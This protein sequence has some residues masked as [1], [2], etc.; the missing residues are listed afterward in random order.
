MYTCEN[1]WAFKKTVYGAQLIYARKELKW[2]F[3]I[4]LTNSFN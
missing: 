4:D 2:D 1:V 3:S